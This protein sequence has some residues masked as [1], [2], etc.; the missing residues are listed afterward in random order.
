MLSRIYLT[1]IMLLGLL[2]TFGCGGNPTSPD[3]NSDIEA[4]FANVSPEITGVIGDY[5]FTG[6]DGSLE[7]GQLVTGPNGE[8]QLVPDRGAS[9]YSNAWFDIDVEYLN[10]RGYTGLGLP[11]YY[12]GDTFDYTIKID[13]KRGL[14]LDM[15]PFLYGK[16]TAEQRYY[17]G[18]A[19]LPG[20]ST[21]VWN[22][23]EIAPNGYVEVT[24]SFTIVPGTVPGNDCT[25]CEID[26]MFRFGMFQFRL[27]KGIC[28]YWDP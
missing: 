14:P 21:E 18:M 13:Y 7:T 3:D 4:F 23:F 19:L 5:T 17:P 12:L 16:L 9:V 26:L 25:V 20:N 24:D 15:Y 1:A 8:V 28:G 11:Y 22:P 6:T 27:I 10:P 2:V